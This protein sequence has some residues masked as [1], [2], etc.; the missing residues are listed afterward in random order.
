[1][2]GQW[3][4]KPLIGVRIPVREQMYFLYLLECKD[5]SI[6]TGITTD[7]SRRFD[8]HKTG[9]GG[10]Y[11]RSHGAVRILHTEKFKTRSKASKRE[12]EI[13]NWSRQRKL[14][15]VR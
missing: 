13:K 9:K 15:L 6:Y 3:P 4:L 7:I 2:V 8:E 10:A 1:M 11:T 14:D 5:K 12:S